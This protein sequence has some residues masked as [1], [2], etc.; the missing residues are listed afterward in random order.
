MADVPLYAMNI[1]DTQ[2]KTLRLDLKAVVLR[3]ISYSVTS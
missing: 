2:I 1:K 3:S